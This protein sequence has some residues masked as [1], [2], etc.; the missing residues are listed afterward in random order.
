MSPPEFFLFLAALVLASAVV[1][2]AIATSHQRRMA[3][4]KLTKVKELAGS[5]ELE[6]LKHEVAELK[7]LV[8]HQAL[9]ADSMRQLVRNQESRYSA[10]TRDDLIIG[11]D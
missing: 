4:L 6:R 5:E 2:V 10:A 7:N 11:R 8:Y 3:E 1:I 9:E